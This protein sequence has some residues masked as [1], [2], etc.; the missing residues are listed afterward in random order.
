MFLLIIL[1]LAIDQTI[2]VWVKT[3]MIE[4]EMIEILSWFKIY[5]IENEGM[6]YGITI[7]SKLV[8]TLF[9][10][11]AMTFA[12]IFLYRLIRRSHYSIGFITCLSMIVAGGIGNIIDCVFYGEIFT[13]SVGQIS[14]LVP[15]GE[16]YGS[17]LHG[18][19]V[20]M[21]YFPIIRTTYPD[22]FPM[23][24]GE[25]FIFFSPIFNFA[26]ACISVGVILLLVCYPRTFTHMLDSFGT[27]KDET[28]SN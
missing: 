7:G 18:K 14:Q 12:S 26:D 23:Y 22:W 25:P 9:R 10:I 1:L 15:W 8:L 21:F 19:V 24:G 2:K 28:S 6:A 3:T 27:K 5:F 20:D 11:V 17:V 13:S 4:T 16:G